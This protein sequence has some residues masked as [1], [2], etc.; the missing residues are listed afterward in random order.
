MRPAGLVVGG[1]VIL[2]TIGLVAQETSSPAIQQ[3]DLDRYCVSCHNNRLKTGGLSL[4]GLDVT[5]PAADAA[6]W[7]KVVRKLR[8][9]MMPPAGAPRPDDA[10]YD[11]LVAHLEGV[12]RSRRRGASQPGTRRDVPAPEPRRIP[13]RRARHPGA[14]RGRG[15]RCCPRTTPATAS[16]T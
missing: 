5:R 9:R 6:V 1:L 4:E 2:A 13:E 14:R 16:T 7:E 15:V 8:S 3:A 10:T 11:A 12:A